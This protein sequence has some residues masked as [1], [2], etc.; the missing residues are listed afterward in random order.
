MPR[1]FHKMMSPQF[2]HHGS[3]HSDNDSL[4]EKKIEKLFMFPYMSIKRF[5][6]KFRSHF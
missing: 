6:S 3:R 5:V 4:I 1:H 2:F